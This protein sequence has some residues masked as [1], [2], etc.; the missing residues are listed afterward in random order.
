V[1]AAVANAE[2]ILV[3]AT[4]TD[5]PERMTPEQAIEIATAW[6]CIQQLAVALEHTLGEGE[7]EPAA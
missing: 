2:D 1:R 6:V 4:A 3:A 7:G 5:L